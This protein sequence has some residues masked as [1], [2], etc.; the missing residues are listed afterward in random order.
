MLVR[1]ATLDDARGIASVQVHAWRAA[2][3]GIVPREFLD[4]LSVDERESRW[5]TNLAGMEAMTCVAED[6]TGVI[7]W[8]SVGP[9]RDEDATPELGELWAIYV[10]PERWRGGVGRAL[11]TWGRARLAERGSRDIVVWVLEANHAA[12]RFY[13]TL[14][15]RAAPDRTRMLEIGG[16][17][18]R[19]VRLRGAW[20]SS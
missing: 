4:N 20:S 3:T 17:R 19:E 14:G 13:E 11:W 7:G 2:Y 5:R 8:A 9:C 12:R 18:I 16:A 6:P 15:F 10:A 1:P